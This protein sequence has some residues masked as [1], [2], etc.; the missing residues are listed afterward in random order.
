MPGMMLFEDCPF[1]L[2]D[3]PP[4]TPDFMDPSTIGLVWRGADVVFL[5][6]DL[7]SDDVI[8]DTQAV[9]A[10]FQESETAFS[11]TELSGRRRFGS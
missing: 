6:I 5:V 8:E 4:V 11:Q 9:L 10:R 7:A 3:L 1:Q 2:I